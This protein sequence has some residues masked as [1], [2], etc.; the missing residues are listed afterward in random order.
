MTTRRGF[1]VGMAATTAGLIL[2][3]TLAENAK[4]A[5]RYWALDRMMLPSPGGW[6]VRYDDHTFLEW[7]ACDVFADH[8]FTMELSGARNSLVLT[9]P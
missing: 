4:A 6:V 2:P 5:R 9:P 8:Q 3:L 7:D 1:L